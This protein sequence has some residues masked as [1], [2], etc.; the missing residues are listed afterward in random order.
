MPGGPIHETHIERLHLHRRHNSYINQT[1]EL[2]VA[3]W[4]SEFSDCC[5]GLDVLESV[6]EVAALPSS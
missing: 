6:L 4:T 3:R 1:V 5:N 2:F